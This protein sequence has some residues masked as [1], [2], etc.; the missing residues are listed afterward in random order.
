VDAL[1]DTAADDTVFPEDLAAKVGVDLSG[2]PTG[3]ATGVGR[4]VGSLRYAQVV[5]RIAD[6]QERREWTAWVGFTAVKLR[7]PL[8][9]FAGFLQYFSANLHGGSEEFE[10]TVNNLYPGT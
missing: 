2:A 4:V 8:L 10:L 6:H 7:Q 5:L 3:I 9:G 1:V